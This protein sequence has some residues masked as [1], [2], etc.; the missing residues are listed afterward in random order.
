MVVQ[1]YTFSCDI[2]LTSLGIFKLLDPDTYRYQ[3]MSKEFGEGFKKQPEY[4]RFN[5]SVDDIFAVKVVN[6]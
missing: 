2:S 6:S 3:N 4:S 1:N 5:V